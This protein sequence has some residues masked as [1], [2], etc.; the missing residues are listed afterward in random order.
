MTNEECRSFSFTD[1][2]FLILFE[3]R[4]RKRILKK[5]RGKWI[6]EVK[7]EV[8][9]PEF[10]TNYIRSIPYFDSL[11]NGA[12]CMTKLCVTEIGLLPACVITIS[13]GREVW[14]TVV[15]NFF[16]KRELE[17]SADYREKEILFHIERWDIESIPEEFTLLFHFYATINGEEKSAI[18]DAD[19]KE[20]RG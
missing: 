20:W 18:Y 9:T 6:T 11:G 4:K 8:V 10:F 2:N 19:R 17:E 12:S 15:F 13:P 1:N 3:E 7:K 14:T 5:E 16:S